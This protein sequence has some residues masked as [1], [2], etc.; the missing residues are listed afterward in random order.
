MEL[1]NVKSAM[2]LAAINAQVKEYLTYGVDDDEIDED[3]LA[4]VDK[5][6]DDFRISYEKESSI[7]DDFARSIE[8]LKLKADETLSLFDDPS[9]IEKFRKYTTINVRIQHMNLHRAIQILERYKVVDAIPD[10]ILG[11]FIDIPKPVFT[12][13]KIYKLLTQTTRK[14]RTDILATFHKLFEE[15]LV[16]NNSDEDSAAVHNRNFSQ[17]LQNDGV[18]LWTKFLSSAKVWLLSYSLLSV[19]PVVLSGESNQRVAEV[20]QDA[21]D[22]AFTPI[23]GRFH[24]HLEVAR[25]A[26]TKSHVVWTFNYAKS[27]VQMLADLS[28]QMTV[29]GKLENL[30]AIDYRG[31]GSKHVSD[32]AVRFLRAHIAQILDEHQPLTGSMCIHLVEECFEL[33]QVLEVIDPASAALASNGGSLCAVFYDAKETFHQWLLME[34]DYFASSMKQ[35]CSSAEG[36]YA[37]DFGHAGPVLWTEEEEPKRQYKCYRSLYACISLLVASAQRYR[38]LPRTAQLIFA[39]CVVEP[40]LCL[41]IGLLL[42]RIRSHPDL[43]AISCGDYKVP[44][45]DVGGDSGRPGAMYDYHCCVQY[46]QDCLGAAGVQGALVAASSQRLRQRWSEVQQWVPKSLIQDPSSRLSELVSICFKLSPRFTAPSRDGSQYSYRSSLD[47]TTQID[48]TMRVAA[49][50]LGQ[51]QSAP[52]AAT[53]VDTVEHCM[54]LTSGMIGTLDSVMDRQ[55]RNIVK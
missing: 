38:L 33:Q 18:D 31:S 23:W 17:S 4:D 8:E 28:S 54:E 42:L 21:L 6:V 11:S 9:I 49:G 7:A 36:A 52:A 2:N 50:L 14:I 22:E 10:I 45:D 47:S 55:Y 35:V 1:A 12:R 32:K 26:G 43:F 15:H 3:Y 5:R 40:L 53:V 27:F 30:C 25:Q 34:V 41:T 44:P 16:G 46:V 24:Y 37:F 39:E 51:K 29:C 13:T 48:S 20:Y 19:L